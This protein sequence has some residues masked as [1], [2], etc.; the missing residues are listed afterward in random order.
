MGGRGRGLAG[1][2]SRGASLGGLGMRA[3]LRLILLG[4]LGR[5]NLSRARPTRRLCLGKGERWRNLA[6]GSQQAAKFD[7][8]RHA[9]P[10]G[11]LANLRR[12]AV[13]VRPQSPTGRSAGQFIVAAAELLQCLGDAAYFPVFQRD[14]ATLYT[15]EN[16]LDRG[17]GDLLLDVNGKPV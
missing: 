9:R 15:V 1:G 14:E 2:G 5:W 16:K 11:M 4:T 12:A 3:M 10:D 13:F 17:V 7:Q 8:R 6:G